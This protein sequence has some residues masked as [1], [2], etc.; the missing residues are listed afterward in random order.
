MGCARKLNILVDDGSQAYRKRITH[1]LRNAKIAH[2][3]CLTLHSSS[4]LQH[5]LHR[6]TTSAGCIPPALFELPPPPPPTLLTPIGNAVLYSDQTHPGRC[7]WYAEYQAHPQ[8]FEEAHL[9]H[10]VIDQ[11]PAAPRNRQSHRPS[12]RTL[13]DRPIRA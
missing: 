10:Q 11:T 9:P 5:R 3:R 6:S 13:V 1:P 7:S 12:A 4:Q 8:V 2:S